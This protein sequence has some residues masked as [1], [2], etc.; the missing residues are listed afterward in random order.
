MVQFAVWSERMTETD[1]RS[2]LTGILSSAVVLSGG[3][4]AV[5]VHSAIMPDEAE[6]PPLA[7]DKAGA[8]Q[9]NDLV[10]NAQA[11][12]VRPRR[13]RR[14]VC[15]WRRGHPWGRGRRVCVWR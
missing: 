1:R 7:M 10:E 4:A 12:V 6:A 11:V 5:T 9:R 3:A 8:T 2:I 13:R 14:R 15:Y